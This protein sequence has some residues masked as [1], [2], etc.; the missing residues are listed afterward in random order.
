MSEKKS[1]SLPGLLFGRDENL[2]VAGGFNAVLR[3]NGQT[4][5]F[6]DEFVVSG[7]GGLSDPEALVFGPDENL[8]VSSRN[9]DSVFRYDG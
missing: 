8:Y 7:S 4:G 1:P 6:I 9:T 2:Y 3:Y 5:A